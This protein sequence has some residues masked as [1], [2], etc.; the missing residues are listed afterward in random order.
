MGQLDAP[1]RSRRPGRFRQR[2][3]LPSV[4]RINAP[5]VTHRVEHCFTGMV[6][7]FL[8]R[9]N[10]DCE[11]FLAIRQRAVEAWAKP[12]EFQSRGY[13]V[14]RD[15]AP[16]LIDLWQTQT[17]QRR[18]AA[19]G[20]VFNHAHFVFD[21]GRFAGEFLAAPRRPHASCVRSERL[22]ASIHLKSRPTEVSYR[23]EAQAGN[24]LPATERGRGS[25]R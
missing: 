18:V 3:R 8:G 19:E 10:S 25:V 22:L 1:A 21:A 12:T 15:A 2:G 13:G 17:H 14:R 6:G 11:P 20:H 23:I 4:V 9:R 16:E 24:I 7:I 5:R